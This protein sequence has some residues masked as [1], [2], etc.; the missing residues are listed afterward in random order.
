MPLYISNSFFSHSDFINY[1]M[2]LC[3]EKM[4]ITYFFSFLFPF[5]TTSYNHILTWWNSYFGPRIIRIHIIVSYYRFIEFSNIP[6]FHWTVHGSTYNSV[7]IIKHS[8]TIYR[9][10]HRMSLSCQK[11]GSVETSITRETLNTTILTSRKEIFSI[12]WVA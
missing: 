6:N 7:V 2:V 5:C 11:L 1:I 8:N 12:F 3:I 9:F 4:Q 10:I